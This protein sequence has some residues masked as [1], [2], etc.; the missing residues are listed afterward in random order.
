MRETKTIVSATVIL[1]FTILLNEP[2][3]SLKVK[4]VPNEDAQTSV[5][6]FLQAQKNCHVDEMMKYSQYYLPI[7][8]LKEAYSR[9]CERNPL[10]KATITSVNL[11]D[12]DIAI[13]SIETIY[14]HVINIR[15][16]PMFKKDGQWKVVMGIPPSGVKSLNPNR[17]NTGHKVAKLFEDY[18]KAMKAHDVTKMKA[19]IKTVAKTKNDQLEQHLKAFSQAAPEISTYG[20]QVITDSLAIVQVETKYS[21]HSYLQNL[22]VYNDHGQ[23]KLIYGQPLTNSFIPLS[24]TSIEVQ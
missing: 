11:I 12:Q 14:K 7:G 1:F 24:Q 6:H 23:W 5:V 13:V 8:N 15:T 22:A 2:I 18:S 17:D 3:F 21:N 10:Q 16:A 19:F 20:V 9:F 4:A